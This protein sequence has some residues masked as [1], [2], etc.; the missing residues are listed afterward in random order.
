MFISRRAFLPLLAT[1]ALS[2][3]PQVDLLAEQKKGKNDKAL[4]FI[5]LG[6]GPSQI[7]TW[8][9][10]PDTIEAS[11]ST[12]GVLKTNVEGMY[13]G[14]SFEKLVTVANKLTFVH[15]VAHP[16]ANHNSATHMNM[17][18]YVTVPSENAPSKEPSFGSIVS[19]SFGPN[20]L[21]N[22]VPH[23]VK[24]N[25]ISHDGAAWMGIT[26]EGF[27][28]NEDG[29][30]NLGLNGTKEQFK[31][32]M[33]FIG[34]VESS[35]QLEKHMLMNSWRDLRTQAGKVVL[36]T[37]ANAFRIEKEK[38]EVREKFGVGKSE[39]GKNLLLARRLI[40]NGTKVVTIHHGGWDNH[41]NIAQAMNGIG[42]E[43]D[44]YLFTLLQDLQDLGLDKD[45]MVVVSGEFGRTRKNKDNGRD[46]NPQSLSILIA[47]G[48]YRHGRTVGQ[49]TKDCMSPNAKAIHP[50]D[51][52]ATVFD[53]FGLPLDLT[54]V[55][56]EKRPRHL[57]ES[58]HTCI[59]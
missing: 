34:V 21:I 27:L 3:L 42:K 51:I 13:V 35:N 30:R 9:A 44:T 32:R 47:G 28:A 11:M 2:Y 10:K 50:Q 56:K 43:L 46:H 57:I 25:S 18:G 1:P 12:T 7:E 23:Y 38:D 52:N 8:D 15:G 45:V 5:W 48:D 14:G 53:H 20:S 33:D 41:A 29:I 37:G 17:T 55:D 26:N 31:R 39:L 59:L 49:T 16:D 19:R 40:Q 24:A 58:G 36:G 54:I 6:G 4:I 22:G